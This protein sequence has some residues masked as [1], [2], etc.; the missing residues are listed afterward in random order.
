MIE[1]IGK[2]ILQPLL[3]VYF[4]EK[5]LGPKVTKTDFRH[6]RARNAEIVRRSKKLLSSQRAAQGY[7]MSRAIQHET[8]QLLERDILAVLYEAEIDVERERNLRISSVR[9]LPR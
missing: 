5:W 4:A 8:E 1:A 2:T 3:G 9:N 6:Y 7:S